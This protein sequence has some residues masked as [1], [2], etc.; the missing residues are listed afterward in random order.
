LP[1]HFGGFGFRLELPRREMCRILQRS[2][3]CRH[4][5]S[6]YWSAILCACRI[7]PVA[8]CAVTFNR[9]VSERLAPIQMQAFAV[10]L[11]DS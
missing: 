8:V 1:A 5:S 2:K 7:S 10:A 9:R 11:Q 3:I 6:E 4:R